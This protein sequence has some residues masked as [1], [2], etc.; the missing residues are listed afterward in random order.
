METFLSWCKSIGSVLHWMTGWIVHPQKGGCCE[1]D[2]S[3]EKED[4]KNNE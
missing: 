4:L 2:Q 3:I 1:I